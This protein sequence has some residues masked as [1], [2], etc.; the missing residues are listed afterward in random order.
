VSGDDAFA[1]AELMRRAMR[2]AYGM[3]ARETVVGFDTAAT[4]EALV[5]LMIAKGLID[6]GELAELR[7]RAAERIAA[8]RAAEWT[9]PTLTVIDDQRE[10]LLDCSSRHGHCKAVCCT[11][12][13]VPLTEGEVRQGN[14]LWDLGA[15]YLLPRTDDGT[16]VNLDQATL[17][18]LVWNDRPLV[19]R[20][21]SCSDDAE[22]WQDFDRMVPVERVVALT[23]RRRM[24]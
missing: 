17:S 9:G 22:V 4:L 12:Y 15:P 8:A 18:C 6:G 21:Y 11:F 3:I 1:L 10:E 23:R 16:C 5:E 13:A 20:R 24:P 2:S 7:S 19:C 14:L